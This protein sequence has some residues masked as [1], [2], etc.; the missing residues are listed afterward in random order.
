MDNHYIV[1]LIGN[2]EIKL[3]IDR[4][5]KTKSKIKYLEHGYMSLV[6]TIS[7]KLEIPRAY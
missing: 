3:L 5:V 1:W 6:F 2:F 7:A 4:K